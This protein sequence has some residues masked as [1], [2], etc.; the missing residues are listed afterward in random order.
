MT[1]LVL[2]KSALI[3]VLLRVKYILRVKAFTCGSALPQCL[4]GLGGTC[5]PCTSA[6]YAPGYFTAYD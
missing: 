2:K 6:R 3:D 1:L 5:P 4:L